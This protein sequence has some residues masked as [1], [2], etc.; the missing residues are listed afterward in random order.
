MGGNRKDGAGIM[1]VQ[2]Q[3]GYL[4]W[5]DEIPAEVVKGAVLMNQR[6]G[7]QVV[8]VYVDRE[9]AVLG[10]LPIEDVI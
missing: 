9:E 3:E 4:L 8:I 1:E 2:G 7:D 5:M 10:F 6:S